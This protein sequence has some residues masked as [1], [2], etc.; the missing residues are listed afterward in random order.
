MFLLMTDHGKNG[1]DLSGTPELTRA[2]LI[3]NII[4]GE[5]SLTP[6]F[7]IYEFDAAEVDD[8]GFIARNVTEDIARE[9]Y[10]QTK[11]PIEWDLLNWLQMHDAAPIHLT[12]AE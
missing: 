7:Q 1:L 10:Q 11:G 2:S 12:A 8:A 6:R 3:A 4:G 5:Y 9:V